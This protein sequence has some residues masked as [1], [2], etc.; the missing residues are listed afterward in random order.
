MWDA[1]LHAAQVS[2]HQVVLGRSA[3]IPDVC[4]VPADLTSLS[5]NPSEQRIH[6]LKDLFLLMNVKSKQKTNVCI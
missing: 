2:G 4:F 3:V 5:K 6:F 1:S